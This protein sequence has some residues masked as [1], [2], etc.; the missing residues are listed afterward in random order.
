MGENS[1]VYIIE[2]NKN[3]K[4]FAAKCIKKNG[5]NPHPKRDPR[6]DFIN[7]VYA[8]KNLEHAHIANMIDYF[9]D[10]KFY[11]IIK[12]YCDGG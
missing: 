11:Y 2:N 3:L 7:E 5:E 9:E 1:G 4:K 10:D 12:E 8:L 6:Q